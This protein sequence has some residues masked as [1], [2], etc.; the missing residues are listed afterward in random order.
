MIGADFDKITEDLDPDVIESLS[1]KW[2]EL[3]TMLEDPDRLEVIAKDLVHHYTE[4]QKTLKGK[5][6]LATSTKLG[7][8]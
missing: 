2:S 6:M 4:K 3:K 7:S 8:C 1:K 5:A